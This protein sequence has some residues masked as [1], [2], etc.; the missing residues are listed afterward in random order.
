M[1][2]WTAGQTSLHQLVFLIIFCNVLPIIRRK[3]DMR[4]IW[5]IHICEPCT[6]AI[7]IM[8]TSP[9][10]TTIILHLRP[11]ACRARIACIATSCPAGAFPRSFRALWLLEGAHVPS[12]IGIMHDTFIDALEKQ[13]DLGKRSNTG[14]IE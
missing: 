9:I 7:I 13:H 1:M 5:M 3:K 12:W 11:A 8:T 2:S 4:Q 14:C 6:Y 10:I